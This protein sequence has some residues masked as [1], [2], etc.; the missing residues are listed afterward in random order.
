MIF[1]SILLDGDLLPWMTMTLLPFDSLKVAPVNKEAVKTQ[2][3]EIE[4][5]KN[6]AL[7]VSKETFVPTKV[8]GS[9]PGHKDTPEL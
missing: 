5:A 1:S 7:I 2:K 6:A 3:D 4:T 8:P 9:V